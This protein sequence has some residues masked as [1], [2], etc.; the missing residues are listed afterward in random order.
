MGTVKLLRGVRAQSDG[1]LSRWGGR[2][3]DGD[4]TRG[5]SRHDVPGGAQ[6]GRDNRG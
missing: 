2:D 3:G 1:N 6:R 4:V 5:R